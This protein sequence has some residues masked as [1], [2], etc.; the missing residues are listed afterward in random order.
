ML[1]A[2]SG[3]GKAGIREQEISDQ[4]E[5]LMGQQVNKWMG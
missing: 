5:K 1:S 2:H 4:G 3:W